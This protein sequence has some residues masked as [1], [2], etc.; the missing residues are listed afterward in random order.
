[1]LL[2]VAKLTKSI[3]LSVQ[4]EGKVKGGLL[5]HNPKI[6]AMEVH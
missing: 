6:A 2:V 1:M 5:S 3:Y 4:E